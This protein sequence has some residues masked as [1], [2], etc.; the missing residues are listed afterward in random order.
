[1]PQGRYVVIEGDEGSGKGTQIGLLADHLTELG[2]ANQVV[3]E[4]GGDPVAEKLREILKFSEQEIVPLAELFGF[5]MARVQVLELVV[6][7]L[8]ARGTWVLSDRSTLSTIIYQGVMRGLIEQNR[9]GFLAAC[10]LA[11][12]VEPDLTVVLDIPLETSAARLA[13]RGEETDRFESVG[14]ESRRKIND[15]YRK[16]ADGVKYRLVPGTGQPSEVHNLIWAHVEPLLIQ[17][18][19]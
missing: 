12:L 16:W 5:L 4:P 3:R 19:T 2:I 18:G 9:E 11:Q 13:S 17:G 10:Q 6:K 14:D 1:M 7:P 8:L 15:G